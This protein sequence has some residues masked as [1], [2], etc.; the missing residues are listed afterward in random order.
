MEEMDAE[1]QNRIAYYIALST[2]TKLPLD[3]SKGYC[4]PQIK[5]PN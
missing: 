2:I 3:K 4:N 5:F 1:A